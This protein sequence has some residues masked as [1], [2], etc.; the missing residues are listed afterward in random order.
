M[1][2]LGPSMGTTRST[3]DV[4]REIIVL[5]EYSRGSGTLAVL[6]QQRYSSGTFRGADCSWQGSGD[7][8]CFFEKRCRSLLSPFPL[9]PV[10]TYVHSHLA[11]SL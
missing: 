11:A 9:E 1:L 2:P 6:A 3:H 7:D 4:E 10:P 5:F 8:S